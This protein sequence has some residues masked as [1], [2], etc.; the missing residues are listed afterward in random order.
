MGDRDV[1]QAYDVSEGTISATELQK[2]PAVLYITCNFKK[3]GRKDA[4][5][6]ALKMQ[7]RGSEKQKPSTYELC[8]AMMSI[9]AEQAP[10][11]A[12][13]VTG[14]DVDQAIRYF[15]SKVTSKFRILAPQ[16]T[17]I[18]NLVRCP[19]EV[20]QAIKKHYQR[21]QHQSSAVAIAA[22]QESFYVPDSSAKR[23]GGSQWACSS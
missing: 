12:E 6:D 15:N 21:Y 18:K 20:L 14:L 7:L 11:P 5:A 13:K 10:G 4:I 19:P 9:V 23:D 8:T 17:A 22:L 2:L 1:C 16:R 3:Q